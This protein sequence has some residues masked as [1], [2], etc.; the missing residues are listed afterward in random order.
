MCVLCVRVCVC[1]QVGAQVPPAIRALDCDPRNPEMFVAGKLCERAG[2]G[3]QHSLAW[4][5]LA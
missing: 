3:A 2:R 4:P 5:C 1:V